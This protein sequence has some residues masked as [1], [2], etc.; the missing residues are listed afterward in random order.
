[1]T[2]RRPD[3]TRPDR[4]L[5][6]GHRAVLAVFVAVVAVPVIASAVMILLLW[7]VHLWNVPV[8]ILVVAGL[9]LTA[10]AAFAFWRVIT[11]LARRRYQFGLRAMLVAFAV[12]ALALGALTHALYH[13]WQRQRAVWAIAKHDGYVEYDPFLFP[14]GKEQRV[15]TVLGYDPFAHVTG[16]EVRS[17]RAIPALLEHREE[18]ADLERLS[19]WYA[20]TDA[21]LK[22]AGELNAFPK[23]RLG[24]FLFCP[25]TD[26]GMRRLG[27]WTHV[28]E[29]FFN[30]CW[31]VTDAGLAHLESLPNLHALTLVTRPDG[32]MPITEAGLVHVGR[33]SQL[34]YLHL[35]GIPITDAGLVHIPSLSNLETLVIYHT[36]AT[37]QGLHEL[38]RKLPDCWIISENGFLPSPEQIRRV[39]IW[40]LRPRKNRVATVSEPRRIAQV[41]DFLEGKQRFNCDPELPM[42]TLIRLDLE[43]ASRCLCQV[44]VGEDRFQVTY[45]GVISNFRMS[46]EEIEQLLDLLELDPA[47][48]GWNGKSQSDAECP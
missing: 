41:R 16:M 7:L 36:N 27:K 19:L 3:V 32:K 15:Q 10:G 46:N 24:E 42:R 38:Y 34:R 8:W 22:R 39:S 45:G 2:N 18:F 35:N 47:A 43:G 23:L 28:E 17:D 14:T 20:V 40:R 12:V 25:L 1:M 44:R 33:M 21:G 26:E 11:A 30:G 48:L 29:L 13:G 9:T 6:W 37:D 31:N 4:P 5:S